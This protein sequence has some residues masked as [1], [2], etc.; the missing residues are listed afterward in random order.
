MQGPRHDLLADAGL[1]GDEDTDVAGRHP[2]SHSVELCHRLALH[3]RVGGGDGIDGRGE[4][5]AWDRG[6]RF[7][8][9]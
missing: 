7:H 4:R 2:R 8:A 9:R 5:D 3:D 6:D 1:A